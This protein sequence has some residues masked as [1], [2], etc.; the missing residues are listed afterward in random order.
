MKIS[1]IHAAIILVFFLSSCTP[2]ISP[3]IEDSAASPVPA[4]STAPST[5]TSTAE[6]EPT[7]TPSA[8]LQ[9]DS[10]DELNQLED[11]ISVE[12]VNSESDSL[13]QETYL[14]K[15]VYLSDG[16]QVLGYV[17]APRDY[18]EQPSPYPVLVYNRG[19]NGD[20]GAVEAHVPQAI[21]YTLKAVVFAS[22]Y[23]ETQ[24][25]TGK[26]EFG[27]DDVHDV[28]KLLDFAERCSFADAQNIILWG[29]SRGSIMT[30]EVIREDDRVRAAI[31]DG[32]VPN[33]SSLYSS[34]E[35]DM[36]N[37]L[38]F[39]VGGSPEEVP[40]EY[41]KRSALL[42][43]DEIDVPLLI[44]HTEDDA[45]A[46]IG[47]V[48]KFVSLLQRLGKDVTYVRRETGGHCY[49]EDDVIIEFFK[50]HTGQLDG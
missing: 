38:K 7:L 43:A 9:I 39:R 14:Y 29:E 45:R 13:N 2:M 48:D 31:V 37:M 36:K 20:Y 35:F 3:V 10:L 41:A 33:L 21:A 46:P 22:Q 26:D 18:L 30:F 11:V 12:A 28:I 44:F 24:E 25:G 40:Q 42:W 47:P 1:G 16:Y 15:I 50:L 19:G 32:S 8:S 17:S 6:N 27:G 49:R 5:P 4:A 34:R 23:R